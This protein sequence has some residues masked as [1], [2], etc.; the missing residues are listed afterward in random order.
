M[1]LILSVQAGPVQPMTLAQEWAGRQ[2]PELDA[3]L[4]GRYLDLLLEK[5]ERAL[6][7]LSRSREGTDSP[8]YYELEQLRRSLAE[9]RE[10]WSQWQR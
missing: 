2:S 4:R 1:Y 5:V 6:D 10:E 9:M 3:P 8:R 7:G